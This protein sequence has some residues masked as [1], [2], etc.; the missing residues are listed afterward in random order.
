MGKGGPCFLKAIAG[1]FCLKVGVT[2]ISPCPWLGT[3]IYETRFHTRLLQKQRL[4][5]G[6]KDRDWRLVSHGPSSSPGHTLLRKWLGLC[7]PNEPSSGVRGYLK[8][9]ISALGVGDQAPVRLSPQYPRSISYPGCFRGAPRGPPKRPLLF[10][11]FHLSTVSLQGCPSPPQPS[12]RLGKPS[13]VAVTSLR[14]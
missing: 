3:R 10:T 6:K 8:V 7:Q 5:S 2:P 14:L 13:L 9:T 12:G 4:V 11:C 1:S